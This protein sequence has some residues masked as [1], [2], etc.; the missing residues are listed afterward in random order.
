MCGV[1]VVSVFVGVFIF[2]LN[3]HIY[4]AA[5]GSDTSYWM[6]LDIYLTSVNSSE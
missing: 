2:V 4:A 6:Y 3:V 1:C 5:F